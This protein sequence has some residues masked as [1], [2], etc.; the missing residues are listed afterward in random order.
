MAVEAEHASR[1]GRP[2]QEPCWIW[3]GAPT[4]TGGYGRATVGGCQQ[5]AHRASY[6][7]FVGPVPDGLEIDHLCKNRMCINPRHLEAVSH[8]ENMRRG[9]FAQATHCKYGHPF[10]ADNTYVYGTGRYCRACNRWHKDQKKHP[11]RQ[12]RVVQVQAEGLQR[13][14]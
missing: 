12:R 7:F 2:V 11:E 9:R 13:V 8:Q 10:D 3:P 1:Q 4:K 6:E 14:G 5:Y